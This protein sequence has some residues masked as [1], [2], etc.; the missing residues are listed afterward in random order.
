LH[1]RGCCLMRAEVLAHPGPEHEQHGGSDG[2]SLLL[3]E[4]C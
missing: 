1:E 2:Q 3:I 4:M